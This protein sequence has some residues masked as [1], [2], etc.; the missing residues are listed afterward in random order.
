MNT[1]VRK[2][3][4]GDELRMAEIQVNAWQRAYAGIMS[5]ELLESL[6][7]HQKS[8]MWQNALEQSGP[9]RYLVAEVDGTVEGFAVFGPARDNDLGDSNAAEIVSININ[10]ALWRVGIGSALIHSI[11]DCCDAEKFEGV[12]LWVAT[13]NTRAR[14]FYERHG[15]SSENRIKVDPGHDLVEEM[16]YASVRFCN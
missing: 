14:R 3:R 5:P 2:A 10:P 9:G 13:E 12:H 4:A 11:I 8:A 6:D 1:V 15:F 7:I 16:R